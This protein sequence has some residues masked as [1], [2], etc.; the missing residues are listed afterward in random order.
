MKLDD[1]SR[2]FLDHHRDDALSS[3]S[4]DLIRVFL[5]RYPHHMFDT[6]T[7]PMS[8]VC[9]LSVGDGRN[10]VFLR[11]V[12]FDRVLGTEITEEMVNL[13][14]RRISEL[15]FD[16]DISVGSNL[17]APFDDDAFDYLVS[18]NSCYY[19]EN[20]GDFPQHLA[21]FSRILRSRGFLV[22]SIPMHSH[23]ILDNCDDLGGGYCIIRDDHCDGQR[24]GA[25]WRTFLDKDEII[26][27]LSPAFTD[28][29][30]A[31]IR[32]DMFGFNYD[33]YIVVCRKRSERKISV[34]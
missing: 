24:N 5:G 14:V 1:I 15:G 12:G 29:R 22:L 8:S 27:T 34:S 33:H 30:V 18:W 21:E 20:V 4:E 13:A 3:P 10:Y 11:R 32:D 7:Y 6:A 2:T 26:E 25:I 17:T 28:F 23:R 16:A 19:V 31:S 9:D